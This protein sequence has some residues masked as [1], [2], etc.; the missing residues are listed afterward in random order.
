MTGPWV[1]RRGPKSLLFAQVECFVKGTHCSIQR[2][3]SV[4][5]TLTFERQGFSTQ[6]SLLSEERMDSAESPESYI[7]GRAELTA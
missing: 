5:D 4:T 7:L 3:A 1:A 6:E 2:E